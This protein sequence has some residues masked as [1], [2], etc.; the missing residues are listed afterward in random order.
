MNCVLPLGTVTDTVFSSPACIGPVLTL[1]A[2]LVKLWL[3]GPEFWISISTGVP[4]AT[5]AV[6]GSKTL[7]A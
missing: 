4:A 6:V 5:L 3:A 2:S 7:S 1:S